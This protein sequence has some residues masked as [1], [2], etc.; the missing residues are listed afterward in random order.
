MGN[1]NGGEQEQLN[2]A[3]VRELLKRLLKVAQSIT[4]MYYL[5]ALPALIPIS[6]DADRRFIINTIHGVFGVVFFRGIRHDVVE[7]PSC[8]D[9]LGRYCWQ[10][11]GGQRRDKI[12]TCLIARIRPRLLNSSNPPKNYYYVSRTMNNF[13][14]EDDHHMASSHAGSRCLGK[15]PHWS[16]GTETL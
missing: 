6:I 8:G 5:N 11:A 14:H 3:T 2:L 9:T 12:T 16:Y 1:K 13:E 4:Q 15:D 10:S 7:G